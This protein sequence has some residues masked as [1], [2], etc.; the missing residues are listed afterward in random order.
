LF[1]VATISVPPTTKD[2]PIY[3]A[4]DRGRE[5]LA[6]IGRGHLRGREAR[7]V[8]IPAGSEGVV[9]NRDI[10]GRGGSRRHQNPRRIRSVLRQGDPQPS[11]CPV[12]P[13][14]SRSK[15]VPMACP[16]SAMRHAPSPPC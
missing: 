1:S 15:A 16:F 14:P 12:V 6:E 3:L 7:L 5:Q 11:A 10:V 4:V 2:W 13:R 9:G 8:R